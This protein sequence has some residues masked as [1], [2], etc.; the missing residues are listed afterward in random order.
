[1]HVAGED[2]ERWSSGFRADE[3]NIKHPDPK[4]KV[5]VTVLKLVLSDHFDRLLL[6]EI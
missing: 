1:M 3:Y 6:F 4:V 5:P 2:E